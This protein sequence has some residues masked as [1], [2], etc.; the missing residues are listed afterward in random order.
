M[1]HIAKIP[2]LKSP[3][4]RVLKPPRAVYWKLSR[5]FCKDIWLQHVWDGNQGIYLRYQTS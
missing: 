1:E 2:E 5:N 3:T 4:R